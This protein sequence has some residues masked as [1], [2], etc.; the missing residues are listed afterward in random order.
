MAKSNSNSK[1]ESRIEELE[2]YIENCKPY[3]FSSNKIIVNREEIEDILQDLR[4]D[5]PDE[6]ERYRRIISNKEA[7]EQEAKERAQYLIDQAESRTNELLSENEIMM[8]ARAQADLIVKQ[9]TEYAQDLVDQAVLEGN[10]YKESAQQ[11]LNDMLVNLHTIIYSCIDNTTKNTNKFLESLNQ[12]GETVQDN[13]NELN[14]VEED[15]EIAPIE[16]VDDSSEE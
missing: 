7:I 11:Y 4:S 1:I 14:Q 9:A 12:V 3:H 15:D 10:A 8:Q 13:L 16:N 2:S 5:I 6:V